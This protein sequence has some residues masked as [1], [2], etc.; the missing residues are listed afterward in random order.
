[1]STFF[2]KVAQEIMPSGWRNTTYERL[3][4]SR[5]HIAIPPSTEIDN[6]QPSGRYYNELKEMESAL[7]MNIVRAV[8]D[9]DSR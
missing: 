2:R 9:Y 7:R 4:G 5:F 3:D 6:G 8:A 1:M